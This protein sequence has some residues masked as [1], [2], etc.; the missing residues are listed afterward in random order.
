LANLSA[1]AEKEKVS[2]YLTKALAEKRLT[3]ALADKLEIAY[4][5]KSVELKAL[6]A[7]MPVYTPIASQLGAG[8]TGND[9]E[10]KSW[11]ELFKSG[12]LA[13]VKEKNPE[14]YKAKFKAQFGTEP[15]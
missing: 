8:E 2:E 6:L 14:L 12:E 13:A 11:D 10:K 9:W 4:A 5:G 15:K 3:K 7:E 1:V